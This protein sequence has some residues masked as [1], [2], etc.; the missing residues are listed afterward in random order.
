MTKMFCCTE[1]MLPWLIPARR[2]WG[3]MPPGGGSA[4]VLHAEVELH[5]PARLVRREV[6]R[7]DQVVRQHALDGGARHSLAHVRRE[8]QA[9]SV[10]GGAGSASRVACT[11]SKKMYMLPTA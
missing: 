4:G 3:G 7:P 6:G 1:K 8:L 10:S 2:N 5:E 9:Q 11:L